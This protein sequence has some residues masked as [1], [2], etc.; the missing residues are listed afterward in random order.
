MAV[1]V[2]MFL[3]AVAGRWLDA[4]LGTTWLGLG[5]LVVGVG[6]GLASLVRLRARNR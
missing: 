2:A 3:P 1:G 4:R 5:G 6:A